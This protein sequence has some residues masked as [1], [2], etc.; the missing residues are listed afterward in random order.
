VFLGMRDAAGGISGI[1]DRQGTWSCFRGNFGRGGD[2]DPKFGATQRGRSV[3]GAQG[4]AGEG[5]DQV[6]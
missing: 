2:R 5:C 6:N 3:G 1:L 4:E